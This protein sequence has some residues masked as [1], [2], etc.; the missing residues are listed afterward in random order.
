LGRGLLGS[1]GVGGPDIGTPRTYYSTTSSF[2]G[3]LGVTM[4]DERAGGA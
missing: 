4:L 1:G 2:V 3:R